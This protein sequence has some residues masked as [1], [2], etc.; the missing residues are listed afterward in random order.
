MAEAIAPSRSVR[1]ADLSD[2]KKRRLWAWIKAND[3]ETG[4]WMKSPEVAAIS[5]KF[6][7]SSPVLDIDYVRRALA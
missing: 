3:P 4:A 1:V 5:A 6:P 7:G 2:V